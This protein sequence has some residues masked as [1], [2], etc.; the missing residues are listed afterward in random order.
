[1]KNKFENYNNIISCLI[2]N[3]CKFIVFILILQLLTCLENNNGSI[4]YEKVEKNKYKKKSPKNFQLSYLYPNYPQTS[5][6]NF[7]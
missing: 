5:I 6:T 4:Y 2:K 3:A 7:F 1:M